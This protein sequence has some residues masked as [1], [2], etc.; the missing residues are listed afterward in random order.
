MEERKAPLL[1]CKPQCGSESSL[2]WCVQ[3]GLYH[4]SNSWIVFPSM[5]G[6]SDESGGSPDAA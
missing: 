4:S 6:T 2:R 5:E 3:G 1:K